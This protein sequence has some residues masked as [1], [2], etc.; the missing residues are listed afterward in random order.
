LA[1][2]LEER[3]IASATASTLRMV[4]ANT[5]EV[6]NIAL[7]EKMATTKAMNIK[8]LLCRE[9]FFAQ[10]EPLRM[11]LI[12]ISVIICMLSFSST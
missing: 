9:N 6:P 12:P 11:M 1:S 2:G 3:T 10:A 4:W 8:R 7:S 5:L